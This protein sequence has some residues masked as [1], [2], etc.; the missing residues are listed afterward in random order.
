MF[1]EGLHLKAIKENI[2]QSVATNNAEAIINTVI[3][4]VCSNNWRKRIGSPTRNQQIVKNRSSCNDSSSSPSTSS[5]ALND[6][7]SLYFGTVSSASSS[8][9][10]T[11]SNSVDFGKRAALSAHTFVPPAGT[12]F[13]QNSPSEFA[14]PPLPHRSNNG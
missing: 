12:P 4:D 13:V 1:E 9:P 3:E 14:K 5:I 8:R 11:L 7:S 2:E 6:N 10:Q